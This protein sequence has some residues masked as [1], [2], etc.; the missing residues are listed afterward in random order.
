MTQAGL[1]F[2]YESVK[3][4]YQLPQYQYVPDFVFAKQ[5][6]V[7]EV[8]GRFTLYDR[9]KHLSLKEQHPDWDIRFVFLRAS[10]KLYKKGKMNYGEWCDKHQIKWADKE[11]PETWIQE[12]L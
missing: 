11:L 1:N 6:V 4:P 7:I 10:L 12:L 9:R 2:E 8:K 5:K 3:L